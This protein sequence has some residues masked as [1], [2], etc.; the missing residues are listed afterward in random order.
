[1]SGN[2]SKVVIV[3]WNWEPQQTVITQRLS[4]NFALHGIGKCKTDWQ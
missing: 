3:P 2:W 1:M 4:Q